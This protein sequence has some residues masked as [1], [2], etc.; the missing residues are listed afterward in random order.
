MPADFSHIDEFKE[1]RAIAAALEPYIQSAKSGDGTQARSAFYDHAPIVGSMGGSFAVMNVDDY[2]NAVNHGGSSPDFEHHIAWIDVSG[3]A[4]A[5]KLESD[6]WLGVRFT[7]FLI[8][9]KH[10]GEWKISGKV[11]NAHE[12]LA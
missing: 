5:V 11:F 7:D 12:G 3:D 1:Y 6:N 2:K 10:N 9:N 8:L 4:A